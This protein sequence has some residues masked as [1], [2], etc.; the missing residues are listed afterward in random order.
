[1]HESAIR[2]WDFTWWTGSFSAYAKMTAFK[3]VPIFKICPSGGCKTPQSIIAWLCIC[4][5][6]LRAKRLGKLVVCRYVNTLLWQKAAPCILTSLCQIG[7]SDY[8]FRNSVD[9]S[10]E[11]NSINLAFRQISKLTFANRLIYTSKLNGQAGKGG[12]KTMTLGVCWGRDNLW[13][14]VPFLRM[15]ARCPVDRPVS[16]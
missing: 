12:A 16:F 8:S 14:T 3:D 4:I 7:W 15:K 11:F 9:N 6:N 5:E 2:P 1:M 10:S 13:N